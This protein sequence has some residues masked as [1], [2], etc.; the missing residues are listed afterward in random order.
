MGNKQAALSHMQGYNNVTDVC[1]CV[2]VCAYIQMQEML[3]KH[4]FKT[5]YG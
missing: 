4:Q 2:P 1:K 3:R 5:V